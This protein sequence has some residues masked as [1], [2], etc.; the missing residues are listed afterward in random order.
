MS[1][2]KCGDCKAYGAPPI[3]QRLPAILYRICRGHEAPKGIELAGS[4][5]PAG[6]TAWQVSQGQSLCDVIE[7]PEQDNR[8]T[9]L[10]NT[11]WIIDGVNKC[12]MIQ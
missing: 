6:G 5:E 4:T 12:Q 8:G 1:T 11:C 2:P 10:I 7:G 9:H 3:C